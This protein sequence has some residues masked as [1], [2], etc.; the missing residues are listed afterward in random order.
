MSKTTGI[1]IV[2]VAVVAAYPATAWW[3]G[4][5]IETAHAR[6]YD[7]ITSLPYL[8][9]KNREYQ[10]GVMSATETVTLEF[11]DPAMVAAAESDAD[12]TA[13]L[14][15]T[16]KSDIQHGPLPGFS[17]VGAGTA[18][19]RLVLDEATRKK[20]AALIGDKDLL[21]VRTTYGFDGGG[22]ARLTS[23]G[24]AFDMPDGSDGKVTW[25]GLS[26]D[27]AFASDMASYTMD[28]SLPKFEMKDA[29]EGHM[30][31]S[32]M[33]IT[34]DQKRPFP[35]EKSFYTGTMN[36]TIADV[37]VTMPT[38]DPASPDAVVMQK[39]SYDVT[40][41]S[42]GD[43]MDMV[44]KIG[45]DT[46][47]VGKDNYGPVHYD[48]SLRHIHA[49]TAAKLYGALMKVYADPAM[50]AAGE[51]D[52][53]ALF[54]PL[55]EPAGELLRHN[56]E[57][58]LDRLSFTTPHGQAQLTA[59]ARFDKLTPE[60]AGDMFALM[61]KLDASGTLSVPEA[62]AKEMAG[63][64]AEMFTA[65]VDAFVEQGYLKREG[66]LLNS[67]FAFAKGEFTVNGLPF[68]PMA[69]GADDMSGME[70]VPEEEA[71][72]EYLGEEIPEELQEEEAQ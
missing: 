64:D 66:G 24:F 49:R 67:S 1:A 21:E 41:P 44:V 22:K 16:L 50:Q 26:A 69:G 35:E 70:D 55:A 13:P 12:E 3:L 34:A 5:S 47:K 42:S 54:A 30:L 23:P 37:N 28:A 48:L 18:H 9:V 4:K 65:Q 8:K 63:E 31:F 15:I 33:R 40:M 62:F 39:V 6:Q 20:V 17:G 27:I 25:S 10:R 61:Q 72:P 7:Q 53:G 43:F 59:K 57:I 45:A 56:P 58:A 38:D 2:A 68:N 19:T 51:T 46:L 32:D 11:T 36:M 29:G 14:V 52:P 71:L 60:E